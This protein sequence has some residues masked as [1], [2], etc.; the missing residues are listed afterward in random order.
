[1]ICRHDLS[2]L[3][4]VLCDHASW[5]AAKEWLLRVLRLPGHSNAFTPLSSAP[6]ATEHVRAVEIAEMKVSWVA[7]VG[8]S[9]AKRNLPSGSVT[10]GTAQSHLRIKAVCHRFRDRGVAQEAEWV[11]EVGALRAIHQESELFGRGSAQRTLRQRRRSEANSR[12]AEVKWSS[13]TTSQRNRL[14]HSVGRLINDLYFVTSFDI[15]LF[16]GFPY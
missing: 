8:E 6:Y 14:R 12:E 10:S 1:M 9:H 4:E 13:P 5:K 11:E 15:S 3:Q 16:S 7:A 2:P